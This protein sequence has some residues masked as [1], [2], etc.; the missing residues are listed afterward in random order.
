MK[1]RN[2]TIWGVLNRG[3]FLVRSYTG[4]TNRAL[5]NFF[6]SESG[7]ILLLITWSIAHASYSLFAYLWRQ[8]I[9]P[10]A[11]AKP[12]EAEAFP[13]VWVDVNF[14]LKSAG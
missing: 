11:S 8:S 7:R 4:S 3:N 1:Q 10:R 5:F 2:K 12:I 13:P 9:L 14:R 6:Y